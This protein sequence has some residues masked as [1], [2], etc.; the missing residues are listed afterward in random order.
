MG[1]LTFV[2][3]GGFS[4]LNRDCGKQVYLGELKLLIND[5]LF[6]FKWDYF[7]FLEFF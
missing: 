1:S 5:F 7:L 4:L 2:F 6:Y 3:I